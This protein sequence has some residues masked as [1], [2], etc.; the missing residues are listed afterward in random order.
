[1]NNAPNLLTTVAQLPAGQR[2]AINAI[3]D[4]HA[5]GIRYIGKYDTTTD[6][7]IVTFVNVNVPRNYDPITLNVVFNF[8]GSEHTRF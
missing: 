4:H 8:D 7:I 3:L 2:D 6:R 5:Y 1:M